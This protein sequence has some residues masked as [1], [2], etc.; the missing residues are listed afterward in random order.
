V[1]RIHKLGARLND[2]GLNVFE[3]G[4]DD[5]LIHLGDLAQDPDA[6]FIMA[7]YAILSDA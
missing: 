3:N 2:N 4:L 1:A 6:D 5:I 7:T